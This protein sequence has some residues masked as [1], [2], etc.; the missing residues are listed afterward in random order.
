MMTPRLRFSSS[1]A[2]VLLIVSIL[3][4]IN[5]CTNTANT[6]VDGE[7]EYSYTQSIDRLLV[8]ERVPEEMEDM[9][10]A[11][12]DQMN[13]RLSAHNRSV[14]TLH[15]PVMDSTTLDSAAVRS[16]SPQTARAEKATQVLILGLLD[17]DVVMS[18]VGDF[19]Q[20]YNTLEFTASVYD[21]TS[22]DRVFAG[23]FDTHAQG[24]GADGKRFGRGIGDDIVD[25]LVE[26][27]LL[28]HTMME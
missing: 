20:S 14:T 9:S 24:G 13:R 28:P 5:G 6:R 10:S 2:G 7:K 1:R 12:T 26:H 17:T 23:T 19:M 22:G 11:M 16:R 15:V 21:V 8:V 27:S 4:V 3:F 18:S 25:A